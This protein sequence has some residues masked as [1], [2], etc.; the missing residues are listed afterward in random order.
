VAGVVGA[1]GN[2]GSAG[3]RKAASPL[4][5]VVMRC[6]TLSIGLGEGGGTL[7][8]RAAHGLPPYS[9]TLGCLMKVQLWRA[10]SVCRCR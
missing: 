8:L 5:T 6:T 2:G 7:A 9:A 10:D 4:A 3:H 1:A